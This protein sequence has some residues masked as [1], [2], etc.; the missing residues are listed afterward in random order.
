MLNLPD[1]CY[2][3]TVCTEVKD[4]YESN[5]Q[6]VEVLFLS[7]K[8]MCLSRHNITGIMYH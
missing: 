4:C 2:I 1:F 5:Y 3:I 6:A 7:S 8:V